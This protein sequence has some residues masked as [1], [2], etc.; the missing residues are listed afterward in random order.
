MSAVNATLLERIRVISASAGSG[1][2][3]RLTQELTQAIINDGIHPSRIIATTFT[4]KAAAELSERARLA[5]IRAGRVEDAEAL[6][7]ARIGTVNAV[8][9]RLVSDFA[10]ELGVSPTS[11][12]LDEKRAAEGF[13][14]CLAEVVTAEER[15]V[16]ETITARFN[17]FAWRE[18]VRA[19]AEQARTNGVSAEALR[20][21]AASS[22]S[23]LGAVLEE[24]EPGTDLDAELQAAIETFLADAQVS[25]DGGLKRGA[26]GLRSTMGTYGGIVRASRYGRL[27]WSQWIKACN[28]STTKASEALVAPIKA[29]AARFGQ[30]PRFHEDLKTATHLVYALAARSLDAYQSFKQ[31]RCAIDFID[32]ETLALELLQRSD[33]FERLRREVDVVFVD[34]FQDTS[35]LQLAIFLKLAELADKSVW[36]GDQKQAIFG[37]R[38]TDP[39][40]MDAAVDAVAASDAGHVD[41][42]KTSYRS[43]P[44]LVDTTSALFVAPFAAQRI[45]A[46]RV[47][48]TAAA[49]DDEAVGPAYERW[50][51]AES[52]P[53]DKM[54]MCLANAVHEML[55][56]DSVRV[57][58]GA[59]TRVV[60][61]GDVAILCRR[62]RTAL[63]V[64]RALSDRGVHA[65]MAK[66][67]LLSTAEGIAAAAALRLWADDRDTLAAAE[68]L[69]LTEYADDPNG[70]LL[71][72]LEDAQLPAAARTYS[73]VLN[74]DLVRRIAKERERFPLASGIEAFDRIVDAIDLRTLCASWGNADARRANIDAMRGHIIA[75]AGRALVDGTSTSPAAMW[76][77]LKNLQ[78]TEEDSQAVVSGSN[79]VS[80]MTW[81]ASKGLEWPVTVLYE[82]ERDRKSAAWGV[83]AEMVP[84][85]A[86][87]YRDPLQSRWVRYWPHPFHPSNARSPVHDRLNASSQH[88]DAEDRRFREDLRLLYVGWTRAKDRLVL[89][90][91]ERD[92]EK[93]VLRTLR[94]A[95]DNLVFADVDKT[96]SAKTQT[97]AWAGHDVPVVVRQADSTPH[98]KPPLVPGRVLVA[99]GPRNHPPAHRRPSDISRPGAVGEV[100]RLGAPLPSHERR[101]QEQAQ[102]FGSALHG[103]LAAD[104]LYVSSGAPKRR[105]RDVALGLFRR[106]LGAAG[107]D[108]ACL[109]Y[110]DDALVASD[111]LHE[112]VAKRWPGS[113]ERPTTWR[114][115]WP[116]HHPQPNGTVVRGA[117]DLVLD[118]V[119]GLVIV[120]HKSF[121][122]SVEEAAAKA[123]T[124]AGQ[125]EAYAAAIAAA[126]G[127]PILGTL[128]HMPL[129]GLLLDVSSTSADALPPVARRARSVALTPAQ[130]PLTGRVHLILA[131]LRAEVEGYAY[132][133]ADEPQRDNCLRTAV[134][135]GLCGRLYD[136]TPLGVAA[137]RA[138]DRLDAERAVVQGFLTSDVAQAWVAWAGKAALVHV[139]EETAAAFLED[140]T[141][142]SA[143]RARVRGRA[144]RRLH[145]VVR[146]V[147]RLNG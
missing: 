124:F 147:E 13:K 19:V 44:A 69:R 66:T 25:L 99:P 123:A 140:A 80:V 5:L 108:D 125:L 107:D 64:A 110:A 58:D 3:Y 46:D 65:A 28:V 42:L 30:H 117:V 24:A 45:T 136:L 35:P 132:E 68:L 88:R 14:R 139:D 27:K 10:F 89:A 86:L 56:D 75:Q 97:V 67:G 114:A 82:L 29:V 142:M 95:N 70:F 112:V 104:V 138:T 98:S 93:G 37:F 61:P 133:G 51:L 146:G 118:T 84:G 60:Q 119:E 128:V 109:A 111:R 50:V 2:T 52:T 90:G 38:G 143:R 106:F 120:D 4:R 145:S 48:L 77:H 39:A 41:T 72:V 134:L 113:R 6:D 49:T 1:K 101:D 130:V 16:L 40:L 103:F 115:E 23:L 100:T 7:A 74:T 59:T 9:G 121:S 26:K 62:R 71:A 47:S 116:I 96:S 144:L 73:P 36:V 33:V 20:G 129:H 78:A 57:R 137:L 55:Q 32:Q 11:D 18:D 43:R 81:H 105:R 21:S 94:D 17:D 12:V 83:S 31:D 92:L 122:G 22:W 34:E 135:L 53:Q 85:Q 76:A 79:A 102:R 8:C 127:R 87:D 54:A 141:G 63:L 131:V 126:T 15:D 91:A